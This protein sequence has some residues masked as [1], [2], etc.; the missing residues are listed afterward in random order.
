MDNILTVSKT[1]GMSLEKEER[2]TDDLIDKFNSTNDMTL[3]KEMIEKSSL[4]VYVSYATVD[5]ID[6]DKEKI[7][8]DDV[9]QQQ[10]ILLRRGG[11]ISDNHTNAHVGKTLAYKVMI[12]P[13]T[14]TKAILHLNKIFRDNPK[15]DDVW[16]ETQSGER[17]GSSIAGIVTEENLKEEDG[18]VFKE[19][20]GFYQYETASANKPSNPYATNPAVSII[21]KTTKG[22]KMS[23][24]EVKKDEEGN[25]QPAPEGAPA[26]T[27]SAPAEEK[28]EEKT[29]EPKDVDKADDEL[30]EGE[31]EEE[32]DIKAAMQSM[33]ETMNSL[34]ERLNEIED[35]LS[36]APEE[37]VDDDEEE[38]EKKTDDEDDEDK[39]DEEEDEKK[40]EDPEESPKDNPRQDQDEDEEKTTK[41]EKLTKARKEI[42]ELKKA[43]AEYTSIKKHIKA[44]RYGEKSIKPTSNTEKLSKVMKS[45]R[46]GKTSWESVTKTIKE[47]RKGE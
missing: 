16:R 24:K 22:G 18:E 29:E 8:I 2:L 37:K 17:K 20:S 47:V 5:A 14:K 28:T 41:S 19:L 45:F 23:K 42:V 39:A 44:E 30:V 10:N 15:D 6:N 26:E 36:G 27:P 38:D 13:I 40:R 12:H 46:E 11:T 32:F 35:K 4:R 43:L 34:G 3:I 21:A 9:I 33:R 31:G 25:G 7:N 1:E